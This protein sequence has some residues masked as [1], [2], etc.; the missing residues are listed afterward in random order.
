MDESLDE[1]LGIAPSEP[2]P[3]WLDRDKLVDSSVTE[4]KTRDQDWEKHN[5]CLLG[6]KT[7]KVSKGAVI[8]WTTFP[9]P[10]KMDG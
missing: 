10:Y 8:S 5:Q 9:H 3:P 7:Y 4:V 6:G 2:G 1:L